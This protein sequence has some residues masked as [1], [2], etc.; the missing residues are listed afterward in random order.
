MDNG[1]TTAPSS[2][3]VSGLRAQDY[4]N[5]IPTLPRVNV[6]P[7][8]FLDGTFNLS[9]KCVA[10]LEENLSFLRNVDFDILKLQNDQSAW[11]YVHR[12]QAQAIL[13]YLYLGPMVVAKDKGYL[14][15]EGI[16]M[17]LAIKY[18]HGLS[19]RIMA[20]AN[21]SATK[22]GIVHRAVDLNSNS[23]LISAFSKS[24]DLINQHMSGV[25]AASTSRNMPQQSMGK[26]LVFCGSGNETSAAIVAAYLMNVLQD[27]DYVKAMQ[28]CQTR[29][30]S[31]NFDDS[32]KNALRSYWD[33][34]RAKRDV[35]SSLHQNM[36]VA[37]QITGHSAALSSSAYASNVKRALSDDEDDAMEIEPSVADTARFDGRYVQPF[38][39]H[40]DT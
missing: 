19:S 36:S 29:R 11:E 39:D 22:L 9:L 5:C 15:S 2:L 3:S 35:T 17:V 27:V 12:R 4:S 6:P 25:Y 40:M 14:Q 34:L 38:Y 13:P 7:L 30:F 8:Q 37:K 24:V 1:N 32:L 28:L 31:S 16:T 23:E 33:I 20:G 26:V 21:E 18:K 10:N